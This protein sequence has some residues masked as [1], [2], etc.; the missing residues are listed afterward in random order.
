MKFITDIDEKRYRDLVEKRKNDAFFLG[1]HDYMLRWVELM[2]QEISIGESVAEAA[3]K[4]RWTADTEM[5]T[6]IM[7]NMAV[8]ILCG[9][10]EHG[11]A[12]RFWHN[13]GSSY[14]SPGVTDSSVLVIRPAYPVP[15]QQAE[16]EHRVRVC[17]S[18]HTL[19]PRRRLRLCGGL[20]RFS[21]ERRNPIEPQT[22]GIRQPLQLCVLR[23]GQRPPCAG[24]N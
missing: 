19:H 14:D 17:H 24:D 3:E 23:A 20:R 11:E 6:G 9:C 13:K 21:N 15:G 10:W 16:N 18:K 4:T 12:L 22:G 7:Y 1:A 5:I 8:R 2:E